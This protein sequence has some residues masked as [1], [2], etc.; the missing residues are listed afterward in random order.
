MLIS[1]Y[2]D[3]V[4]NKFSSN[5][6]KKQAADATFD[7]ISSY[8]FD[9]VNLING[10]ATTSGATTTTT[11]Y[12]VTNRIPDTSGG[13]FFRPDR[14][15]RF[16]CTAYI[17][18]SQNN[19]DAY[20][21]APAVHGSV[22]SPSYVSDLLG[23]VGFRVYKGTSYIVTKGSTANSS[24]PIAQNLADGNT[25]Y[26]EIRY[27]VR[28]ADFYI[29]NTLVGSLSCDLDVFSSTFKTMYPMI[30]PIRSVTGTSVN[31][32]IESYQILQEK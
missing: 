23:Y 13:Q 19:I 14:I 3:T 12:N 5:Q 17:L 27:N 18:G 6:Q 21:L 7:T 26:L 31:L 29:N 4:L 8:L 22:S 15:A 9:K 1:Y 25:Y 28:T 30:T 10:A 2:M 16:R 20:I 11:T 24:I 32:T